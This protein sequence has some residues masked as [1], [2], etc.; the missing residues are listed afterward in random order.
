MKRIL[1]FLE[2]EGVYMDNFFAARTPIDA[3]TELGTIQISEMETITFGD[4]WS[5]LL[6]VSFE[7]QSVAVSAGTDNGI[8]GPL[9]GILTGGAVGGAPR[10][11]IGIAIDTVRGTKI[12]APAGGV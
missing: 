6:S 10:L 5:D 12:V 11:A 1:G 4:A 8:T 3:E 2:T 9:T 7:I